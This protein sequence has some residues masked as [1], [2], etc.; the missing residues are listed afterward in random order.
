[1][2]DEK[3]WHLLLGGLALSLEDLHD[4]L[5][6]LDEKSAVILFAL[7]LVDEDTSEDGISRVLPGSKGHDSL[8]PVIGHLG[9]KGSFF[10]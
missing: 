9:S 8:S 1:M 4:E 7:G 5:L 2:V 10:R 6:I 3:G